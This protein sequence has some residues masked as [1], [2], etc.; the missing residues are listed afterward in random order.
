MRPLSSTFIAVLKPWPSVP[1]ISCAAGTR[2][3]SKITSAVWA[4]RWPI[5]LSVLPMRDAGR[6]GFHDESRDAAR[7]LVLRVGARHQREDAGVRRV[8]DEALGAVDDVVVAV[9]DGRGAQR[10]GVR[11]GVR[12][13]QRERGDQLAGRQP[14]Q[15]LLLLR[16]GAVDQDAL[17]ADAH[18]G[19]E[20]RAEA[21]AR[22]GPSPA[23]PSPLPPWSGPG[24][25]TPRAWSG[26]TGPAPSSRARCRR[27]SRRSR[28]PASSAGTSRSRT[29]RFTASSS[30]FEG[31]GVTDHWNSGCCLTSSCRSKI[32]A[33][34]WPPPMHMVS[35]P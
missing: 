25:R 34:P 13:G 10:R 2:Q 27:G 9:A 5:F 16:L 28:R 12:L 32:A 35:R 6:V 17:R 15:V 19:A 29:K 4:P 21:R 33:M 14:R 24:R 31:F 8:G 11:A 20:E 3:F 30:A 23:S 18:R 7:A 1:P 22:S 26:R